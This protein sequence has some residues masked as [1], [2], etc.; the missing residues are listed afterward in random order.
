M[1]IIPTQKRLKKHKDTT[2]VLETVEG[3]REDRVNSSDY[4][5][6]LGVLYR[7]YTG[8]LTTGD[9][10]Y[11]TNPYNTE[12]ESLKKFP[13]RIRNYNIIAGIVNSLVGEKS[14]RP[15]DPQVVVLND[16]AISTFQEEKTKHLINYLKQDYINKLEAL[17]PGVTGMEA[18]ELDSLP[19]HLKNFETKYR[20]HRAIDGQNAIEV[21]SQDLD[22]P[23]VWQKGFTDY[24]ITGRVLSY[25]GVSFNNVDYECIP[26]HELEWENTPNLRFIEDAGWQRR[27][28]T[29]T[30]SQIYDRWYDLIA[31]YKEKDQNGKTMDGNR[32]MELL[33][34]GS[35]ESGVNYHT[36]NNAQVFTS[37]D[38]GSSGNGFN[39]FVT[40]NKEVFVEHFCW[41]SQKKI[42]FLTFEDDL[43][44]EQMREVTEDYI[45][46]EF[47][48][49]EWQWVNE[50]YEAI[51]LDSNYVLT[52]GPVAVQRR[53]MDN[54]SKNKLPYNGRL[55]SDYE[56][57]EIHSVV[58]SCIP[59]QEL[60]NITHY[61]LEFTMAKNKDKIILMEQNMI[62][63]KAGFNNDKFMYYAD[64]L[65]FAFVDSTAEVNGKKP[66]FN[67]W[68]VLDA[69]LGKSIEGQF[70]VLQAI[71][72]S[73]EDMIG[74]N[75]QRMG[76]ALASDSV[77]NNERSLFQ[78]SLFTEELFRRFEYFQD[79][80]LQGLLD[81]SK[82]AWR[83]GKRAPYL[84]SDFTQAFL[85]IDPE[86]YAESEFGIFARS[87]SEDKQKLE[88][89]KQLFQPYMQNGG[90]LSTVAA[91]LDA[92]NYSRIK[93][94]INEA[95]TKMAEMQQKAAEREEKIKADEL[96]AQSQERR[97]L[98]EGELQKI[99]AKGNKDIEKEIVKAD[100]ENKNNDLNNN[101][102]P[103][104]MEAQTVRQNEEKL[105]AEM[106]D[107][108]EAR[109]SNERLKSRELDIKEKDLA[110]KRVIKTA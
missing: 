88:L 30:I 49:V 71:K 34:S 104:W 12:D 29:M 51:I 42:G 80:E 2:W 52:H 97:E 69:S 60:Y 95:D 72:Q 18:K 44:Q 11:V 35:S 58:K 54:L 98:L 7:A 81:C 10:S 41:Q 62:P 43:G 27:T 75:R 86:I 28:T 77:G 101:G 92:G 96:K 109:D 26:V 36:L 56:N 99:E 73:C 89:L 59:Y 16:D 8:E 46:S 1:A 9:Y 63:K 65:G 66:N 83:E 82:V 23:D 40:T 15:Y 39:Y 87:S 17:R 103:D 22:L 105:K 50:P 100:L 61:R 76:K 20:D 53:S 13:A 106:Q 110:S 32:L 37:K 14:K 68:Q 84:T 90:M 5:K 47:E 78:S 108:R 70:M 45:P 107:R 25:K 48:S 85:D 57:G 74:F 33:E 19:T 3:I 102:T 79:K 67:Q 55:F 31:N 38:I 94:I 64:A 4:S 21:L 6:E 24:C 93:Q 91:M